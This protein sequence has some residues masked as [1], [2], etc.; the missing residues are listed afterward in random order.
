VSG[1]GELLTC[2]LCGGSQWEQ[3]WLC[4]VR[5]GPHRAHAVGQR[6]AWECL[7][8]SHRVYA[9]KKKEEAA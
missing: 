1:T 9:T 7:R 5:L 2:V 3:K 4:Q 8:C 6:K